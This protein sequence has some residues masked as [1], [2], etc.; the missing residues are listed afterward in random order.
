MC[1]AHC[2]SVYVFFVC[3]ADTTV[4][5]Q[6]PADSHLD[7]CAICY[8]S[9]ALLL[10]GIADLLKSDLSLWYPLEFNDAT[11]D[12]L[13]MRQIP[14]FTLDLPDAAPTETGATRVK[15]MMVH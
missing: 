4:V 10:S 3:L 14:S 11:G 8:W 1:V 6:C 5:Y 7:L 15:N 2:L 12:I 9:A 13:P